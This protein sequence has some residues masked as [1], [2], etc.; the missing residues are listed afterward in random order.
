MVSKTPTSSHHPLHFPSLFF[1]ENMRR[2]VR[3]TILFVFISIVAFACVSFHLCRHAIS[4]D[5][6]RPLPVNFSTAITNNP[7]H[8]NHLIREEDHKYP[9]SRHVSSVQDPTSTVSIL[10]PAWEVLVVVVESPDS[11][12]SSDSGE[13]YSCLFQNNATSPARFAGVLPFTNLKTFKCL[14][15]STV[16]RFLPF[17][18]PVLMKS[19][20]KPE[21]SFPERELLR[22][23]FLAYESFST[24]ADVVL[25]AKGVNKRQGINRP[26]SSLRCVFNYET[27][28]TVKTAVISSSQEVFRCLHPELTAFTSGAEDRIKI[29]LEIT[30]ENRLV[31]SVAYYTPRRTLSIQEAK[32]PLCACTMVYN[33]AK[34]LKE[35]VVYH[36]NIGVD[37]FILYDNDSD[38]DLEKV[39]EELIQDGYDVRTFFWP[40]PKTQEAGFS[41]CAMYAKESCTWMMYVDVDEF[42]FSPSW[43]NSSQPSDN[44]LKSLLPKTTFKSSLLSSIALRSARP[45]GQVSIMCN[46]FG[47]SNQRSHPV[48]GVTQGYICRRRVEQ[49]HKSIVLLDAIS[50]SLL[51]VIHHF[52]LKDGYRS[53]RLGLEHAVVNHYK[54]Q[55]WSEF[56]AKFRRRVSAYVIDWTQAVNP[57]VEGSNSRIRVCA[58]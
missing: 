58:D 19:P 1:P 13:E 26:P 32:S 20:E 42:V 37:N 31:P 28:N 5:D 41:H 23:N 15:P 7:Y 21:K 10:L 44:M 33:V 48:N 12:L 14:L 6:L 11:S 57:I 51:N 29:S 2:K 17:F 49:R 46:E 47:P 9:P 40:W 34:F 50:P 45:V 22:W 25:F 3:R 56:K 52:Q 8:H 53:K 54:Y 39:V 30:D 35:W 43:L 36:S 55:A 38:D 24:E 27:N 18:M 4:G 16:R